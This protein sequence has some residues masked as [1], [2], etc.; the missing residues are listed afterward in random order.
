MATQNALS[1]SSYARSR[2]MR[3]VQRE[4]QLEQESNWS[5]RGPR[6]E[7]L[8]RITGS[9]LVR[10]SPC[11]ATRTT[12]GSN[13]PDSFN[14]VHLT[15][16]HRPLT[17]T[18]RRAALMNDKTANSSDVL[19]VE[20]A[21]QTTSEEEARS[22]VFAALMAAARALKPATT[23]AYKTLCTRPPA[24]SEPRLTELNPT[25]RRRC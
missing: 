10:R 25:F 6:A 5:S 8:K 24:R 9:A 18:G 23:L 7:G 11:L 22:T 17:S 12:A 13:M 15:D 20:P 2:L 14:P 1:M 16:Q 3:A 19:V 4:A 21:S